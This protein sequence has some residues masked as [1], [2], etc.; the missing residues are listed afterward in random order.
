LNLESKTTL[1]PLKVSEKVFV[2]FSILL[3][4]AVIFA[5]FLGYKSFLS[6]LPGSA[7]MKFNTALVFL[8]V[9]INLAISH[10]EKKIT[11]FL[12]NLLC[13]IPI[14]IGILTISEYVG[15][16]IYNID[17][18]IIEDKYSVKIPG[19]MSP[20]TAIC[21]ILSGIG[22][23]GIKHRNNSYVKFITIVAIRILGI[24][25]FTS[26]VTFI[27]SIPQDSKAYFFQTMAIHTSFLFMC[28]AVFL[29]LKFPKSSFSEIIHGK[30]T[31]SYILRKIL[32]AIILF[33]IILTYI[34][35]VA[36][37][38]QKISLEFGVVTYVVLSIP[39]TI[40]Y[41][42]YFAL[43]LNKSDRK[44]LKLEEDLKQKN[45][46]LEQFAYITSHDLQ[47]PL[48][49]IISFTSLLEEEKYNLSEL[50]QNSIEVINKSSYRMKSFIASLLEY[51]KIGQEKEKKIVEVERLINNVK[52]D[53]H[54]LIQIKKA[55]VT[56]K[57][58]SIKLEVFEYNFIK[59]L[60]RG[61]FCAS[62]LF[63]S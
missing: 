39:I 48:N 37:N 60:Q 47:E 14:L 36:I 52:E 58:P 43:R 50:G 4:T 3:S 27:L 28:I 63:I 56:Y 7:T 19:R 13:I 62:L 2:T 45:K 61:T 20:A 23:L 41:L 40:V 12:Y 49:S 22:L 54:N 44:R 59:L 31:G 42:V 10:K 33:P 24:I 25:S 55:D 34:L 26:T 9:S 21:S 53:L 11:R 16:G 1:Y 15:Y 57:G 32:P 30:Y 18:L 51:S 38:N 46:D 6:I 35:F 17:N 29:L 8:F 5:W